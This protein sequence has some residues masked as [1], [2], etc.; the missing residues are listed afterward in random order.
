[1]EREAYQELVFIKK[2]IYS[3]I[4]FDRTN[5]ER[6]VWVN[7]IL[8]R[9]VSDDFKPSLETPYSHEHYRVGFESFN[10]KK[11]DFIDSFKWTGTVKDN[12]NWH[13]YYR[14]YDII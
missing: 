3:F 2:I 9:E 13:T 1:M 4:N 7:H 6:D 10:K 14:N 8:V 5:E 11:L 12:W